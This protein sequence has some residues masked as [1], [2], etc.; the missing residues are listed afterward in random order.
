MT[1]DSR[2]AQPPHARARAKI[3]RLHPSD[4]PAFTVFLL[5]KDVWPP[6]R[7][8]EVAAFLGQQDA[9]A[10]GAVSRNRIKA[11]IAA[12]VDRAV[13]NVVWVALEDEAFALGDSLLAHIEAF[14]RARHASALFAQVP[15]GSPAWRLLRAFGCREDHREQAVIAGTLHWS[16]DLIKILAWE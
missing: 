11:A 8:A 4:A 10:F 15:E 7:E 2:A 6:P 3:V 13:L 1:D 9:C 16:V 14:G 12:V 5:D